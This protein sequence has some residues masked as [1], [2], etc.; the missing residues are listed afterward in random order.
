[1]H[2]VTEH[3]VMHH[4]ADNTNLFQ[5]NQS[6]HKFRNKKFVNWLRA[7][8]VSLNSSKTEIIIF[9]LLHWDSSPVWPNV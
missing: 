3:A 9:K 5:K 2:I 8:K 6:N 1:M 7:N 4:F